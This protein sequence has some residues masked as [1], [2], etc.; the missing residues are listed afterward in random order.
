MVSEHR[1]LPLQH[2]KLDSKS[3]AWAGRVLKHAPPAP[4]R[5]LLQS[6]TILHTL[7]LLLE[8]IEAEVMRKNWEAASQDAVRRAAVAAAGAAAAIQT[9]KQHRSRSLT[10]ALSRTRSLLLWL[11]LTRL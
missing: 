11:P 10:G 2:C 3:T 9:A 5:L 7:L 8:E 1:V 4:T 6:L